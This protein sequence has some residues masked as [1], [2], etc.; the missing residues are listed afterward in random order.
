MCDCVIVYLQGLKNLVK[1]KLSIV[2]CPPVTTVL[3]K[4]PDL[5]FQLGFSVQN[6]IVSSTCQRT[7]HLKSIH[8]SIHFYFPYRLYL[9]SGDKVSRAARGPPP[10]GPSTTCSSGTA[11]HPRPPGRPPPSSVSWVNP[12]I[13][14]ELGA[15]GAPPAGSARAHPEQMPRPPQMA[16]LHT[17]GH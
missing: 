7:S 3:I 4:R 9:N 6:G 14:S 2:S 13:S 15:H 16:P 10:L 1:V 11:G 5:K 8:P 17:E 12:G